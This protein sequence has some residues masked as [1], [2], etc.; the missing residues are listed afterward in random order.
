MVNLVNAEHVSMAFGTR[1]LLDDVSLGLGR[2]DVIGVVGRNG[3]GKTTL[4]KL[5]TGISDPDSGRVTRTGAVSVG[6]LHQADDFA[7]ESTVRDVIVGG[8]P[9]H[10][11]ASDAAAR[12]VV[13]APAGRRRRSTPRSARSAAGSGGG[14]RWSR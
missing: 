5:L 3:D 13:R 6:Y 4:L 8:R 14:P 1:T 12:A 7:A 9:D 10:V 2:G 11:W